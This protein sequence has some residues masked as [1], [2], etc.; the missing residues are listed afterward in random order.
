MKTSHILTGIAGASLCIAGLSAPAAAATTITGEAT[1]I[2]VHNTDP[3]LVVYASSTPFSFSLNNVGDSF[4]TQVMTIGTNEG[5]VE[6]F[7]DTV[8]YLISASFTFA[9]PAGT[10][11]PAVTGSTDGFISL[12]PFGGCGIF[13][14]GCGRVEWN[15]PTIF[16]FG[17]GGQF[18]L[19]LKDA[20]FGTPGSANI[21]GKFTLLAPSVP[22]P[23]TWALMILGFGVVGFMMRSSRRQNVN[24]SYA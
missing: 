4:T 9:S 8:N 2:N 5:S 7:E 18:S 1:T 21:K 13:D 24:V 14:G 23:S 15:N 17:N 20:T 22:E 6:L 16:N 10:S 3:G 12:N 11:G 19:S